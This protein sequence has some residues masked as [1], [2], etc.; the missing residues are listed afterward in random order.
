MK[1]KEIK[2]KYPDIDIYE[3]AQYLQKNKLAYSVSF[4]GSVVVDEEYVESYVHMLKNKGKEIEKEAAR[5]A[6]EAA[7]EA[8]EAARKKKAMANMLI[9][10]GFNFDGYTIKKYSGY[11]SG[12]DAMLTEAFPFWDL[13]V[14]VREMS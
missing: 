4:S 13:A 3:L 9:T 8:E 2:A 7:I 11:I 5:Q 14:P 12:D 6:E 10:S 1:E